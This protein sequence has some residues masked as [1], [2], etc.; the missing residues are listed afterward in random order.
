M[1][2]L[3]TVINSLALSSALNQLGVSNQVLTAINMEPIAEHYSTNKALAYLE[4]GE[5]VVF[6]GG[7][8]CPFFTT[9]TASSLRA[10]EIK[11]DLML[12]GTRV[13]GV[14][15]ADPEKDPQAVKY[16]DISFEEIYD[17]NL[18]IMDLTATTLCRENN[19]PVV[20]FNMDKK[21]NLVKV[22]KGE[23]I[24]TLVHN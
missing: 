11:A 10:V 15:T 19:L 5:V 14:Y 22:L 20:V 6:S 18:K 12:K 13:D 24:G 9:D 2:M 16:D 23:N 4:K 1:G 3:A 17:K 21:G 7:T 8:G